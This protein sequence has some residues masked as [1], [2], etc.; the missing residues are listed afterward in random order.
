MHL[1]YIIQEASNDYKPEP[2]QEQTDD[3]DE[4][5]SD[6]SDNDFEQDESQEK[7]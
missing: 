7:E 6:F 4:F 2:I 5:W 3:C 1:E